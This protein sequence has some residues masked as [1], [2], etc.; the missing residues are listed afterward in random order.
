MTETP[1]FVFETA[2]VGD[3]EIRALRITYRSVHDFWMQ[4]DFPAASIPTA[5]ACA[6]PWLLLPSDRS[7]VP[8]VA[9]YTDSSTG[10]PGILNRAAMRVTDALGRPSTLWGPALA[11]AVDGTGAIVGLADD[12]VSLVTNAAIGSRRMEPPPARAALFSHP[13]AARAGR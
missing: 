2:S 4:R 10:S 3:G 13:A 1:L 9:L 11:V 12:Q 8:G 7:A 5:L 6:D